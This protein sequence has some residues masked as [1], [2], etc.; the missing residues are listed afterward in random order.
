MRVLAPVITNKIFQDIQG[1]WIL[2]LSWGLFRVLNVL[3]S[4]FGVS[5]SLDFFLLPK[6]DT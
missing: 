3:L 5:T 2:K 4:Y 6:G 1:F